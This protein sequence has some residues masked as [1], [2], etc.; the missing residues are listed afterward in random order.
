MQWQRHTMAIRRINTLC[1]LM[2]SGKASRE[3]TICSVIAA[4]ARNSS[5]ST[6][7]IMV[8]ATIWL[9]QALVEATLISKPGS[10]LMLM[11]QSVCWAMAEPT[12]LLMPMHSAPCC[13][14]YCSACSAVQPVQKVSWSSHIIDV[15]RNKLGLTI[16]GAG[17]KVV[18]DGKS[19][20]PKEALGT[21]PC[22]LVYA[23]SQRNIT[24]Q[25]ALQNQPFKACHEQK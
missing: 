10:A 21:G 5:L 1:P 18:G 23:Y 24:S 9:V 19:A 15:S 12:V 22:V 7:A 8:M 17:L 4:L 3:A 6:S 25:D 16:H 14:A 13:F 11:P 2:T 20:T